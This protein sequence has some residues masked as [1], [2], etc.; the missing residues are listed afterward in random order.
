M[1]FSILIGFI[2]LALLITFVLGIRDR[3]NAEKFVLKKLKDNYGSAPKR[4]YKQD[5][6]DHV[7]GFYLNHQK[8]AQIDDITWNDLGMDGVYKRMNYCLSAAGEEYL[9]YLLRTPAQ[10]DDFESFEK[11]VSFFMD[12]EEKR[13]KAQ[14]IFYHIGNRSR[15]SIYDYLDLLKDVP[16]TGNVRHFAM[17]GLILAAIALCFF[18]FAIG[19]IAL[20]ILCIVQI[21]SYFRIKNEI[22]PYLVTYG[23]IMRV[24]R[25][26]GDISAITD[27][28]FA[29]DVKELK[30]I[31]KEFTAFKAGS[32]LIFSMG[33]TATSGNPLD[34][35][36][37]YVKMITHID[38]I[39]FNQMYKQ[40]MAKKDRISRI[41]EITG[42]I[43]A[44]ISVACFRAS[45]EGKYTIPE[46]TATSYEGKD[47]FHPLID[48]AVPNSINAGRGV[49]L[50]GS[51]AAGKSTFLKT[52]AINSILAQ[53][54][55]TVLGSEYNAPFYRIFSSM[56][57]KDDI[58]QGDSYYIVEIKSIKRIIDTAKESGNQVLCFV[59]EVLRGTNTVE[60]IA[61]STQILKS[62]A[63][64]RVQCFA[65]THDIELT[66]LLKDDYDIY[67]FEGEVTDDDVRFDYRL[68][69]GPT[70]TRN[71]IQLLKV[72]GYDS[73]IVDSAQ[74]MADSFLKT[75]S[76]VQST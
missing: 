30:A 39:K 23:Y 6:L 49:L 51:N 7:K 42:K 76:W 54:I 27:D 21:I 74:S 52:C 9:Y 57:L 40:I 24:I 15:Y 5:D 19:F 12:N 8:D 17:L 73:G 2:V 70:T 61:A 69:E 41:L 44:E 45:F 35:L 72:L 33:R 65:A 64:S 36:M 56:A 38:L 46:F 58:V 1:E 28:V 43:E 4:E 67:H 13:R 55:H 11:Q 32:S 60:R 62:L 25:S 68:K 16:G 71:A 26:I 37:D 66:V 3:R 22:E 14:L 75:G 50:T 18:N 63:K 59:D 47:L 29:E 34:F 20:V 10:E 53:S 31:D 48:E